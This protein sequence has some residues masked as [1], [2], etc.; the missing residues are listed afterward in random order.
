MTT[1]QLEIGTEGHLGVIALN[2]PEAINA[3]SLAMIEGIAAQLAAWRDDPTIH[4]VLFEG[5][6]S[7]GFCAGGDVRQLRELVVAGRLEAGEAYFAAEYDMD[8]MIATY[9][10][11]VISLTTGIVM[12]GGLGVAGHA[13]FRFTTPEAGSSATWASTGCWPRR[14][15][16]GRCCS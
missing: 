3:L 8:G 14:P 7:R 4:A 15:R 12:G 2:R 10:K 16:R 6:G 5:R 9:P 13:A 1:T 11:P